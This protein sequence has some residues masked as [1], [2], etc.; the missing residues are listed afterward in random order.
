[1]RQKAK[2]KAAITDYRTAHPAM[3]NAI[4]GDANNS[5]VM[6]EKPTASGGYEEVTVT[7]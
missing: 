5:F 7:D 6:I 3:A 1:M 2:F 4:S